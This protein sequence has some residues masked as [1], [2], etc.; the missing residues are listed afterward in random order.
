MRDPRREPSDPPSSAT[1]QAHLGPYPG[2]PSGRA[3]RA[4]PANAT[5][6]ANRWSTLSLSQTFSI[7][8]VAARNPSIPITPSNSA[9]RNSG[10]RAGSRSP[11]TR[12]TSRRTR[13]MTFPTRVAPRASTSTVRCSSSFSPR[14]PA[15]CGKSPIS[16][17]ATVSTTTASTRR[18][19][20]PAATRTP[21]RSASDNPANASSDSTASRSAMTR[22]R[23]SAVLF[24]LPSQ[25]ATTDIQ[26]RQ[27]P[28]FTPVQRHIPISQYNTWRF[29]PRA[30][31]A[32]EMGRT[33]RETNER[34]EKEA[35]ETNEA[36]EKKREANERREKRV[37]PTRRERRREGDQR[38][39]RGEARGQRKKRSESHQ[40]AE[41]R[42]ASHTN[43]PKEEKQVTPT[44]RGNRE[45]KREET[46]R[47]ETK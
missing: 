27:T 11:D 3:P 45:E 32:Q 30:P 24:I 39:E 46:R 23:S 28:G 1:D 29:A 16:P 22:S 19:A 14:Q 8:P 26:H 33:E 12:L 42:E 10:H 35:S 37:R 15:E 34:K 40:R 38:G 6:A 7:G 31:D 21:I 2:R 20:A 44:S 9:V 4:H 5:S 41:R 18:N 25:P 47:D 43:E 13:S 36:R 17:V